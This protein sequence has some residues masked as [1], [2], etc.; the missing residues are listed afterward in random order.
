MNATLTNLL[1]G[2]LVSNAL[3][4]YAVQGLNFLV[5]LL[6]LPYLLRTLSA[7]AYG[8]IIFAQSLL[9]Y[10]LILTEFGFNLTAARDISVA[11]HDSHAVARIYWTTTTAKMLLML[12]AFFVTAIVVIATPAFRHQ[13][14]VFAASALLLLG[15]VAFPQ[16]Y[17]QGEERLRDVAV[18]QVVS[19][20]L[21]AASAILLVRSPDDTLI[22][23]VIL[24]APQLA[25]AL[26]ALCLR[27][28]IAPTEFYRPSVAE[29]VTA[30]RGSAHM[31]AAIISTTLYLH[32]NTVVLGLVSGDRA[33]ALYSVAGKLMSAVQSVSYPLTQ[34]LFPR[35][36]YL[37][38][39]QPGEAWMLLRRIA[40][41][42]L[43][44]LCGIAV[45]LALFAHSIVGLLGGASY[46]EAA[47]VVQIMA[48]VPILVAIATILSQTVMVNVGLTKRLPPIYVTVGVLNLA[49]LFPLTSRFGANGAA[50]CLTLAETLGPILMVRVLLHHRRS[51]A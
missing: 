2:Q 4:L 48:P 5:P 40:R 17:F 27:K 49:L 38:S 7:D 36:S 1:R 37:F 33:V 16:W 30:L 35:A 34:A 25:G 39:H 47:T 26:A 11:R 9:G 46:A 31:F 15:N 19:K 22:A 3:S 18:L 14:P 42:L 29:I 45:V 21:V 23:A 44:V 10:G 24:S 8:S 20:C 13:W 43:P 50:A 12:A 6:L 41:L 32:T 28:R 51:P